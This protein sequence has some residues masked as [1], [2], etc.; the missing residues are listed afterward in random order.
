MNINKLTGSYYWDELEMI[1]KKHTSSNVEN[2]SRSIQNDLDLDLFM[3]CLLFQEAHLWP[4]PSTYKDISAVMAHKIDYHEFEHVI[5]NI[6]SDAHSDNF[7]R[8]ISSILLSLSQDS[9]YYIGEEIVSA[10]FDNLADKVKTSL[11]HDNNINNAWKMIMS[12]PLFTSRV[13]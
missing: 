8:V 9:G 11:R 4:G 6:I 10:K 5:V 2:K 1:I 7:Q 13:I 12:D 3:Y